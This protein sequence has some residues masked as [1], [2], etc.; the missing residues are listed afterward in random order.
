MQLGQA[1]KQR[2]F[3]KLLVMC[4]LLLRERCICKH[5]TTGSL[6]KQ[7][8]KKSSKLDNLQLVSPLTCNA[9]LYPDLYPN[10]YINAE[11]V[12]CPVV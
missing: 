6:E 5:W 3:P 10:S 1:V 11:A 9:V 12:A 7:Q 4:K 8:N 2:G